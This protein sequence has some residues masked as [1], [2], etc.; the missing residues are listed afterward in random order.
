MTRVEGFV[1]LVDNKG[2]K[3]DNFQNTT[4]Y[5]KDS[6]GT[7][8]NCSGTTNQMDADTAVATY[9]TLSNCSTSVGSECTIPSGTYNTSA[10]SSCETSFKAVTDKNAVC[11]GLLNGASPDLTAACTCWKEAATLVGTTKALKC[12]A[13]TDY[14]NMNGLKKSCLKKFSACKKAEDESV[15]LIQVCNGRTTPSTASVPSPSPV[16]APAPAPA[17]TPAPAPAPVPAPVPATTSSAETTTTIAEITTLAGCKCGVKKTSRIV[18]GTETEVN[19]Y[20]WMSAISD[21]DENQF[22][23]GTLIG[24]QWVLSASHCFLGKQWDVQAST[25]RIVLG[26]HDLTTQDESKIP[27]KVVK[28]SKIITHPSYN[29]DTSDNDIALLKLSEE[30]DLNVYTPACVAKTGETLLERML[31]CMV[32][33]PQHP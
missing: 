5:L 2:G 16:P 15:G 9:A 6:L 4:S 32:G 26:E 1:K 18:G 8:G 7:D 12:S 30:V 21:A 10:L 13:K 29:S 27:K 22:C 14:D 11:Q 28:V 3:K 25:V 31:G 17:P 33:E 24:S 20:P 19:E 23:G